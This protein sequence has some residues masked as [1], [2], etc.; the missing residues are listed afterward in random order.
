L[1]AKEYAMTR[2]EINLSACV[3]TLS[4]LTPS[5][6]PQ[7][8]PAD[9]PATVPG[10]VHT[11]LMA[12]DLV[13]DPYLDLN[14]E[15]QHWIGRSDWVYRTVVDLPDAGGERIELVCEGLD[16]IAAIR[17]NGVEV[18]ATAN[19]HR[20]YRFDLAATA[21]PGRNVLE[22]ELSSAMVYAESLEAE[23][24]ALPNAYAIPFNFIRKMACNFGWD[25]GPILVTAGI[26]RPISIEVGT[27]PRLGD[28]RPQAT[29]TTDVAHLV[30]T[31][32]VRDA[33]ADTELSV[34][35]T[36]PGVDTV[37]ITGPIVDADLP[38]ARPWWP[39]SLGDQPLYDV[40]V[41]LRSG[42]QVV[43]TATT[44]V[45]FRTVTLDTSPDEIGRRF[46]LAVN[47]VELFARGTNWIP[48]DS[49]VTRVDAARYAE[50]IGQAK[51]A[52]VDLVRVWGGGIYEDD[53]FYA[54]CDEAGMLVWQD[55]LFAC[56]AYPEEEPIRSEVIA[57]AHD[58]VSRLMPH[59]SLVLWN[60]NNENIWGHQDWG[61]VDR[62]GERTWGSG[63]YFDLLPAVVAKIDPSRPYW[64]GS[65]WSGDDD[66]HP[67]AMTHGP[68]HIWD[69]WNTRDYSVYAA[70]DPRF[71][72][73]FG[74]QGPPTW[75]TLT[76]AVHDDPMAPDSPGML[77]HEKAA[78]GLGKLQ[79]GLE[80]H[81]TQQDSPRDWDFA[82]W[83]Y[84]TQLNQARAVGFGIRHHRS[85]RGRCMGSVVWQLND[86]WPVSSWAALDSGVRADGGHIGHIAR[87]KPLWYALRDAFADR[88]I[89]SGDDG[90]TLVNDS[91]SSWSGQLTMRVQGLDGSPT[92]DDLEP[93][94]FEVPPR[95]AAK[96]VDWLMQP[97]QSVITLTASTGERALV[98]GAEDVD[99]DLPAPGYAADVKRVDPRTVSVTVSA[100]TLLRS[101]CLFADRVHPNAEADTMVVDLLPG[102]SHTFV[103]TGPPGFAD[104]VDP[105]I[106]HGA[107][108]LRCVNQLVHTR[109]HRPSTPSRST[110]PSVMLTQTGGKQ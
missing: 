2:S 51:A 76:A 38:G 72:S 95:S 50:R 74:F 32:E 56:A 6:A 21:Q 84:A 14:E 94:G 29:W 61:W 33:E 97:E 22:V 109:G 18:G 88:L 69:V 73:E 64:P 12:A 77:A 53:A 45:G 93:T 46:T 5:L 28:L 99:L 87:R 39:H 15:T 79:R 75:A 31:P 92:G 78:D 110:D 30:L 37:E 82:D 108:V 107:P 55:F 44:Q 105:Q 13:A 24:G 67:N 42:G 101:L 40:T 1:V 49:F 89:I 58:N 9:I 102:E 65:P 86:C 52:N 7:P 85:L 10:C 17:L 63:Y 4:H 19:M 91:G 103:V 98:F 80:G 27:G 70:H 104:H 25:W 26:W 16:T 11:D 106:W 100:T 60:G 57:E 62:L 41:T 48:D 20:R 35:V 71:V 68:S 90:V 34:V 59:P 96:V 3:W 8:L 36:G 43:D 66:V 81:L 23:R 54:A 47:G 83:H